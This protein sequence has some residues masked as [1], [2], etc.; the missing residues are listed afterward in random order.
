MSLQ[1]TAKI[2]RCSS[3]RCGDRSSRSKSGKLVRGRYVSPS[4]FR[5]HA[6]EDEIRATVRGETCFTFAREYDSALQSFR[7]DPHWRRSR[8]VRQQPCEP[9]RPDPP[10]GA[11]PVVCVTTH[12]IAAIRADLIARMAEWQAQPHWVPFKAGLGT[13]AAAFPL[14]SDLNWLHQTRQHV[15]NGDA[16]DDD[17]CRVLR[18]QLLHMLDSQVAAMERRKRQWDAALSEQSTQRVFPTGM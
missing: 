12:D 14:A 6:E 13:A 5:Q 8:H 16:G 1:F 4:E 7:P 17:R 3:Y 18:D 10:S 11:V 2:C 9:K 15:R